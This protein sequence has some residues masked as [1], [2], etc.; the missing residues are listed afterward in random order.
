MRRKSHQALGEFLI[1]HYLSHTASICRTAFLIGCTQ[2]DWNPVT[3]L[4]GSIR[5][6]WLRGHNY[7]NARRFLFRKL[8][9]LEQ[10]HRFT[11]WDFY[12]LGKLLHYTADAFT[13][14]HNCTFP[15][16]I[17]EHR[18]YEAALQ[19]EFLNRLPACPPQRLPSGGTISDYISKMHQIYLSSSPGIETDLQFILPVCCEIL[20][21]LPCVSKQSNSEI[22]QR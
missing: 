13:Y 3:Y 21:N 8:N 19:E 10:S 15:S 2:P 7:E 4:K 14:A 16:S 18:I 11:L 6:Q 9:H 1:R 20:Q 5:A 22:G 17:Q 12:S